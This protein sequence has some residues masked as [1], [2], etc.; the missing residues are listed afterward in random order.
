ME[1]KEPYLKIVEFIF[2]NEV[3]TTSSPFLEDIGEGEGETYPI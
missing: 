2:E 3:I 1:Y